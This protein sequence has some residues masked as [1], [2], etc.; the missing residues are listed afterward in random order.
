M[1]LSAERR[2]IQRRHRHGGMGGSQLTMATVALWCVPAGWLAGWVLWSPLQ[3]A[4]ARGVG[5]WQGIRGRQ[6]PGGGG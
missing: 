6:R 1:A 5:E 3:D 4:G 2:A